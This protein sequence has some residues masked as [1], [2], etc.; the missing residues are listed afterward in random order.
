MSAPLTCGRVGVVR[1]SAM[2]FSAPFPFGTASDPEAEP[3]PEAWPFACCSEAMGRN[4]DCGD[5]GWWCEVVK[6]GDEGPLSGG[7]PGMGLA[8]RVKYTTLARDPPICQRRQSRIYTMTSYCH[9]R[10]WRYARRARYSAAGKSLASPGSAPSV[11]IHMICARLTAGDSS[12]TICAPVVSTTIRLAWGMDIS[13]MLEV[14][15]P[16]LVSPRAG[17]YMAYWTMALEAASLKSTPLTVVNARKAKAHADRRRAD[18]CRS[19]AFMPEPRAP[20]E[21]ARSC[22]PRRDERIPSGR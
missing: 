6:N 1:I 3:D 7:V 15:R 4:G 13:G 20:A 10:Q 18:R 8:D 21:S 16:H 11:L 12:C 17:L 14:A 5:V 9:S 19:Y 2:W 22:K